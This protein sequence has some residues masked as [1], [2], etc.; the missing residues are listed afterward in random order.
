MRPHGPQYGQSLV[1]IPVCRDCRQGRPGAIRFYS[2]LCAAVH[3]SIVPS[4]REYNLSLVAGN[5]LGDEYEATRTAR[6]DT[7]SQGFR[8][9][10]SAARYI[11]G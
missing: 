9:S 7:D 6:A 8:N 11:L 3:V 4:S 10:K 5:V 2:A 1:D